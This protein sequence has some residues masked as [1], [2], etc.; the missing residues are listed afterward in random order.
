MQS[1]WR[2]H[3]VIAC[4]SIWSVFVNSSFSLFNLSSSTYMEHPKTTY[5]GDNIIECKDAEGYLLCKER[6]NN[7]DS[8]AGFG[9]YVIGEKKNRCCTKFD[10]LNPQFWS[11]GVSYTKNS[12]PSSAPVSVSTI[13]RGNSSFPYNKGAMI[14]NLPDGRI[15]VACQAGSREGASNQRI[16]YSILED[17]KDTKSVWEYAVETSEYGKGTAQWEPIL[18][19]DPKDTLWMFWSEGLSL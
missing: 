11:Q 1:T 16:L 7:D 18:F 9:L 19:L 14:E 6:C 5:L 4:V 15:A 8:C 13:F 2:I 17:E 3:T 10:N 12:F